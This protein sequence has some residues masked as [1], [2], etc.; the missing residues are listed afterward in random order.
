[1]YLLTQLNM[2][3]KNE[4]NWTCVVVERKERWKEGGKEGRRVNTKYLLIGY[5][6]LSWAFENFKKYITWD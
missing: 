2:G 5:L 6:K 4:S 1:M 3:N